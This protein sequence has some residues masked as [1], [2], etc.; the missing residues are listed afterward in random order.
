[1][2][3][4]AET[5]EVTVWELVRIVGK[6]PLVLQTLKRYQQLKPPPQPKTPPQQNSLRKQTARQ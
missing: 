2:T 5:L 3:A 6:H 1:M 4:L